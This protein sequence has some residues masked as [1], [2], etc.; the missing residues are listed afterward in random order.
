MP[1]NNPNCPDCHGAGT[2][3]EASTPLVNVPCWCWNIPDFKNAHEQECWAAANAAIVGLVDPNGGPNVSPRLCFDG[4][5]YVGNEEC[6]R[7][8]LNA[9]TKQYIAKYCPWDKS[10]GYPP[11]ETCDKTGT[12]TG[13]TQPPAPGT[14]PGTTTPGTTPPGGTPV[15]YE[16]PAKSSPWPWILGGLAV[17]GIAG[18]VVMSASTPTTKPAQRVSLKRARR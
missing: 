12:G 10:V 14:P 1:C 17:A 6:H 3:G 2:L 5:Q 11:G 9:C 4:D 8:V 7:R 15:G 18:I 13:T 16:Q